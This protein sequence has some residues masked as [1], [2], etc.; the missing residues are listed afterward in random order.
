MTLLRSW[1]TPKVICK[2]GS[3]EGLGLFAVEPID[4][5]EMIGVK[6]GYIVDEAYVIANSDV[7][8]GSHWQ[9]TDDLFYTSTT[10]SDRPDILIGFNHSCDPNAYIDGQIVLKA[11]RNIA[12]DEEITVD[13]ATYFISD[14]MEFDC[15]CG[16]PDCRKHIKPSVDWQKPELQARYE[17]YFANVVQDKIDQQKTS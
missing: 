4:K 14:T 3:L 7:I 2:Q 9:I 12:P 13:Y 11:M 15:L 16:K 10:E 5:G 6:T 17:G 1:R 8:R